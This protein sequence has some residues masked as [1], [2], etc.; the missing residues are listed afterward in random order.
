MKLVIIGAV[1]V[2]VAAAIALG[3]FFGGW[4]FAQQSQEVTELTT[5]ILELIKECAPRGRVQLR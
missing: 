4:Y 2:V 3:S 1:V 5:Q